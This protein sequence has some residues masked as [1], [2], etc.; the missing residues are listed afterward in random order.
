MIPRRSAWRDPHGW[1]VRG[2]YPHG[3][4]SCL[5]LL[6]APAC[7][8]IDRLA[9]GKSAIG[10][11]VGPGVVPEGETGQHAG[12]FEL[13][14]AGREYVRR[15]AEVALQVAVALR[16][17]QQSLHDEQSP[18]G[19]DNIEGRRE[20]AHAVGSESGFIQNGE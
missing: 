9:Q 17:V 5:D 3:T 1:D 2:R 18:P 11:R 13:A 6:G 4:R 19:S 15:H 12:G 8:R 20:V 10:Q 7:E 14:Q 16:P